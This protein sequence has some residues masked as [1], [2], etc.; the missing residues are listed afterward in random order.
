MNMILAVNRQ[1]ETFQ[2]AMLWLAAYTWLLRLPSE[3]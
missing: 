3:V 1:L 2:V